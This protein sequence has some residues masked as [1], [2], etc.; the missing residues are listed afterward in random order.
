MVKTFLVT[1]N[2]YNKKKQI[3]IVDPAAGVYHVEVQ[4]TG[5]VIGGLHPSFV[6]LA[7]KQMRE[8]SNSNNNNFRNNNS[9]AK[10]IVVKAVSANDM[11][12]RNNNINTTGKS[13][14]QAIVSKP[15]PSAK[16]LPPKTKLTPQPANNNSW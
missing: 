10:K 12:A 5:N 8:N 6:E 11:P 16:P 3:K 13:K 2:I 7:K 14:V 9:A 15:T 4:S 1:Q